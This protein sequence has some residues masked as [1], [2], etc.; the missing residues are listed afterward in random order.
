VWADRVAANRCVTY[1][2]SFEPGRGR[3]YLHASWAVPKPEHV[4]TLVQ[5]ARAGPVLGVDL[6][7][8]HLAAWVVDPSGN[9]VGAPLSVPLV[10]AGLCG[11]AR[12]HQVREAITTLIHTALIH[13]RSTA[14]VFAGGSQGF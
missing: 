12:D 5:L 14:A 3:W 1:R 9:P 2:I 13:P 10:V 6:N 4:P 11:T 7:Q 8:G